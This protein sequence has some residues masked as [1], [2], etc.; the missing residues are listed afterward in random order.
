MDSHRISDGMDQ[1]LLLSDLFYIMIIPRRIPPLKEKKAPENKGSFKRD[2]QTVFCHL[3]TPALPG[4]GFGSDLNLSQH[5]A[6][7]LT[8]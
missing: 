3:P 4:S 7:H 6:P 8:Y 1:R 2:C 5:T